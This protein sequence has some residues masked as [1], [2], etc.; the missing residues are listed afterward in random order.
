MSEIENSILLVLEGQNEPVTY[1]Y[2]DAVLPK[3]DFADISRAI[4]ALKRSGQV[5]IGLEGVMLN[6][7]VET[8]VENVVVIDDFSD[9]QSA[10]RNSKYDTNIDY[11]PYDIL[12]G[13]SEPTNT[14]QYEQISEEE[15]RN[16][17]ASIEDRSNL[18]I[19]A[20]RRQS[21]FQRMTGL[22]T[23]RHPGFRLNL[24]WKAHPYFMHL[25][26]RNPLRYLTELQTPF[27]RM[28]CIR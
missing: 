10:N 7:P 8:A 25:T 12:I 18:L 17:I 16:L 9:Q 6:A 20:T 19:T 28:D 27:K 15:L 23:E 11:L 1:S 26:L 22:A 5:C 4:D 14:D 3:W 13:G 2:I 21:R 24:R